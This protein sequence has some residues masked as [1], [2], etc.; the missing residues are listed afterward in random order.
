LQILNIQANCVIK[1]TIPTRP[2]SG[3]VGKEKKGKTNVEF[4][5]GFNRLHR[6]L[7]IP[8]AL[9]FRYNMETHNKDKERR[10]DK[11]TR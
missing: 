8:F 1:V 11:M 3:T 5:C 10:L 2:G 9:C 7:F 6:V 4:Y